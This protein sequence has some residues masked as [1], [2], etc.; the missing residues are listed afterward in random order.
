MACDWDT[1][2][3]L[4]LDQQGFS[5]SRQKKVK[6]HPF[7][8]HYLLAKDGQPLGSNT[9]QLAG[10]KVLGSHFVGKSRRVC[11]SRRMER[12]LS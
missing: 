1:G 9:K 12:R 8:K 7:T 3:A 4:I 11:L 5:L 2:V 10:P 6:V